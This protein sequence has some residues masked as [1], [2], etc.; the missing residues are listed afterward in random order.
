MPSCVWGRRCQYS[1]KIPDRYRSFLTTKRQI[2]RRRVTYKH[3]H[4]TPT[5]R[6]CSS[7]HLKYLSCSSTNLSQEYSCLITFRLLWT[8]P[9]LCWAANKSHMRVTPISL[10][11]L[12]TVWSI[13]LANDNQRPASI[14]LRR[15][16]ALNSHVKIIFRL[17]SCHKQVILGA[18]PHSASP[19]ETYSANCSNPP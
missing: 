19:T 11:Q 7:I 5:Q 14:L 8:K 1:W 6:P 15:H 17:D 2:R 18:S 4:Y 9:T 12:L 3:H 13:R 10:Q 16:I